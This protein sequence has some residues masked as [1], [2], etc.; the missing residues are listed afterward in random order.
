[1]GVGGRGGERRL[2]RE[3]GRGGGCWEWVGGYGCAGNKND[4][5]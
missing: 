1:M 5:N 2:G 3:W 4:M